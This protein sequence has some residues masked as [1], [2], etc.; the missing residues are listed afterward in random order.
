MSDDKDSTGDVLHVLDRA[1]DGTML[2]ARETSE[3]L[4][5]Y[6]FGSTVKSAADLSPGTEYA[7]RQADGTYR[8]EGRIPG[9]GQVASEDYRRGWD[10]VFGAKPAVGQA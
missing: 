9:G 2:L 7:R 10:S 1:P 5:E 4:V 3:G 6:G 8:V